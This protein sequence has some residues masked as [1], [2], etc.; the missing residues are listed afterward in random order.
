MS[1]YH[2][3]A[4][5]NKCKG[6][7]EG[8]SGYHACARKQN[9]KKDDRAKV[10]AVAAKIKTSKAKATLAKVVKKKKEAIVIKKVQAIFDNIKKDRK[11]KII[12]DKIE[13]ALK[14]VKKKVVPP[15]ADEAASFMKKQKV[16]MEAERRAKREKEAVQFVKRFLNKL[17]KKKLNDVETK[18]EIQL[19]L[20][21]LK[22][23]ESEN[24]FKINELGKAI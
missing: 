13:T 14:M 24:F 16:R 19:K 15:K 7:G 21:D 12:V 2:A 20:T 8:V 22:K 10:A 11:Q 6:L 5:A 23:K 18:N 3:C 4:S 1:I 17:I 9:C